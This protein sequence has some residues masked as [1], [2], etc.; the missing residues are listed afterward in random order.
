MNLLGAAF[1]LLNS[2]I[3]G[4]S[5]ARQECHIPV[6][7]LSERSK[8][9]ILNKDGEEFS[10]K[11]PKSGVFKWNLDEEITVG[12][13]EDV[14]TKPCEVPSTRI[15]I[16]CESSTQPSA[17]VSDTVCGRTN[18]GKL[19]D[20]GYSSPDGKIAPFYQLCFDVKKCSVIY[21]KHTLDGSAFSTKKSRFR[22]PAPKG[23]SICAS[24][25]S[26]FYEE[27]WQDRNRD[28]WGLSRDHY[29]QRAP[30]VPEVDGPVNSWKGFT[31][32]YVN[33]AP[34]WDTVVDGNW[35]K[36]A[37]QVNTLAR[38]SK[39]SY[40]VYSGVV[41]PENNNHRRFLDRNTNAIEIPQWFWKA[42]IQGDEGIVFFVLN[43][44]NPP[45]KGS[46]PFCSDNKC[47]KL[48]WQFDKADPNGF[49]QCCSYES[50]VQKI[51]PESL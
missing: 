14:S 29:F 4:T 5:A 3:C 24:Y 7:S 22:A 43:D 36:V 41:Y 30:L 44:K 19:I 17:K 10:L 9:V 51:L 20:V 21:S 11:T 23:L 27:A 6:D 2:L 50:D 47:Q 32:V 46:K 28:S 37:E 16:G 49:V 25:I 12:C 35:A 1:I 40:S 31:H 39:K 42:V 48:G 38:K 34:G 26:Y 13:P 15:V 45:S 18:E 8:G 33:G